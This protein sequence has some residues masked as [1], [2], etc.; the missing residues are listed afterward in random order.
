MAGQRESE[1]ESGQSGHGEER[2]AG[3]GEGGEALRE[4]AKLTA[5]ERAAFRAPE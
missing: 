3:G 2:K 5:I 1:G 4:E